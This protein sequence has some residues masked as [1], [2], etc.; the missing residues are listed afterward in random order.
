M[1]L[2]VRAY[3]RIL[4]NVCV[5]W[6]VVLSLLLSLAACA[7]GPQLTTALSQ[8]V[9]STI[10]ARVAHQLSARR[11]KIKGNVTVQLGTGNSNTDATKSRGQVA[12]GQ[13]KA[14]DLTR[15]GQG[16][17]ALATESGAS[18]GATTRAGVPVWL[19]VVAL[20]AGLVLLLGCLA[21]RYRRYLV[22]K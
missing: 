16:G 19:L 17:G 21:Y 13:A 7:G 1:E 3:C 11:V 18:A 14:Q 8:P 15:A 20:L 12:T 10:Q 4:L 6:A 2:T 5:L 22:A 9:D